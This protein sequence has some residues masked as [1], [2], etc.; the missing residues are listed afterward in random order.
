MDKTRHHVRVE[1]EQA[2]GTGDIRTGG[3]SGAKLN[4]L[5]PTFIG[6]RQPRPPS[7]ANRSRPNLCKPSMKSNLMASGED[8]RKLNERCPLATISIT[9][10]PWPSTQAAPSGPALRACG[11][12]QLGTGVCRLKELFRRSAHLPCERHVGALQWSLLGPSESPASC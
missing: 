5:Q 10:L 7:P 9:L 12:A 2:V 1:R 4:E 11:R 3:E 6:L 8:G